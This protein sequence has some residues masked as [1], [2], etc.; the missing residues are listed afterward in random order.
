MKTQSCEVIQG[1]LYLLDT[2]YIY[3][4]GVDVSL[5]VMYPPL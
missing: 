3:T 2:L 4:N 1:L 5:Y